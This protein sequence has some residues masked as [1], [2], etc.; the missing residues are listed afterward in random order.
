MAVKTRTKKAAPKASTIAS[1]EVAI[2]TTKKTLAPS[3]TEP[4]L[5][6]V[7]PKGSSPTARIVTLPNPATTTPCRFFVCPEKGF[8]EITQVAP[9]KKTCRS[10]L[11]APEDCA[12]R[13]AVS[14]EGEGGDEGDADH[15]GYVLEKPDL[16]VATP[17]DPLFLVLPLLVDGEAGSYLTFADYAYDRDREGWEH[18]QQLLRQAEFS[19]LEKAMER[20]MAAICDTLDM[21]DEQDRM[22]QL[23]MP[24]LL[25]ELVSKAK[26]MVRGGLPASMEAHFVK[27]A[28]E[29]PVLS[30]RRE[31][32]SV[33]IAIEDEAV[34]AGSQT[35][36]E[37]MSQVTTTSITTSVSVST[38]ATSFSDG[39][40][41]D[42]PE[43]RQDNNA[44]LLR[45]RVAMN[46]LLA[47]YLPTPLRAKLSTLLASSTTLLD[48][49]PLDAHLA[50]IAELKKQ[51]QVLRSL[52]DNIS[53]KRSA[54]DDDEAMAK[55]EAK[56]RKKD[57]DE[58][59]KK[60]TSRGV[61]QLAK[62]DTSGMKKLSSFFTKAPAKAKG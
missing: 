46:F 43:K 30:V 32:S 47:A 35:P 24:K 2:S 45:L 48:F 49:A 61:T 10:W 1:N 50:R 17:C 19:R 6:V 39:A 27:Q 51:A 12:A 29:M 28:L 54:E 55:L 52:S 13:L 42:E 21:G 16:F 37:E 5:L 38:A 22:Y 25:G 11:L 44:A 40:P 36:S 59:K 56:K 23:S 31:E 58:L 57:E 26:R 14:Q 60:Y 9:P 20:R 7:L 15:R 33:S 3:I 8:F 34:G 62:A 41:L 4:P 53:R 18:L